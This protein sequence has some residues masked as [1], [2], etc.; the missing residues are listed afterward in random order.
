[1]TAKCGGERNFT[2]LSFLNYFNY[3]DT[4]IF[5]LTFQVTI[6]HFTVEHSHSTNVRMDVCGVLSND[7]MLNF[8][9][10]YLNF[11]TNF[12]DSYEI[13]NYAFV[14]FMV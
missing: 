1:M 10:W 11:S 3:M 8:H 6:F 9:F 5:K 7:I 4:L 2:F 14:T 13:K 12:V